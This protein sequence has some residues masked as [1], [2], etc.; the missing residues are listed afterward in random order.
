MVNGSPRYIQ[1]LAMKKSAERRDL[2]LT[3]LKS[4]A[5]KREARY[6]LK[7]YPLLD[8]SN[9]YKNPT[10]LLKNIQFNQE[11]SANGKYNQY[12]DGTLESQPKDEIAANEVQLNDLENAGD[13][14]HLS[15]TI[16]VIMIRV[17]NLHS[18]SISTI[19]NIGETLSKC[20]RLGASPIIVLENPRGNYKHD[21][22]TSSDGNR[23]TDTSTLALQIK[24]MNERCDRLVTQLESNCDFKLRSL[25]GL[26]Q[27][28]SKGTVQFTLPELM[29]TPLFQGM[30]P[31]LSPWVVDKETT[32]ARIVNSLDIMKYTIK[33]LQSLDSRHKGMQVTSEN[34]KVSDLVTV[35]KIIF[36]DELG[37]TPSIERYQSSHVLI[38]LL[39]EY[40]SIKSELLKCRMS[41]RDRNIHL[42]NL[43]DMNTLLSIATG[44]TGILTT[45]EIAGLHEL[46]SGTNP[47]IH[48]ILTDRPTISSSLPVDLKKTPMLNTTIIKK[49]IPIIVHLS[50]TKDAGLDIEKMAVKGE[51]DLEKLQFLIEDSFGRKLDLKHYLERINGH[52][53]G[54]IIAGNYE[55]CAILTWERSPHDKDRKIA[56]L[57]K[58]AVLKRLQ[59]LPGLADIVFKAML[60]NFK[61]ELIWRSRKTNPVNKWYFDR[62]TA[63]YNIPNSNWR[64]FYS[65]SK[66]PLEKDIRD[67]VDVC[68]SIPPSFT[69]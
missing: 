20:M 47:I 43:I 30:I 45:P 39:Q 63:N 16:R 5:T 55:G 58:F 56:Y 61:K 15:D 54:L 32:K 38:N 14:I 50:K 69:S 18:L 67:Y 10:D 8:K 17:R 53:S 65:G 59:G 11:L 33:A 64:M 23:Q 29:M 25:Q 19:R 35:E 52:I 40:D 1:T 37:G 51:I 34:D 42:R 49:G 46:G 13:E 28:D 27:V 66:P 31:V 21:S 62:S 4:T 60:V 22:S 9:I 48:N 57:D 68:T 6:Y 3:I 36:I 41:E 44:A 7:R 12:I 2:I 24:S 26:F